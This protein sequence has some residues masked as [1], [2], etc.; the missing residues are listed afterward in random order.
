[1]GR[2][3]HMAWNKIGSGQLKDS[4]ILAQHVG[5]KE[6]DGTHIANKAITDAHIDLD[7][8]SKASF[9]LGTKK[10]VDY[11]QA[12]AGTI[13]AGESTVDLSSVIALGEAATDNDLG[14]VIKAPN[15]KVILTEGND[16]GKLLID[17]DTGSI[18]YGRITTGLEVRFFVLNNGNETAYTFPQDTAYNLQFPA[19]FTLETVSEMFAANEKFVDGAADVTTRL[20]VAQLAG[21]IFGAGYTL[22]KNGQPTLASG[23]TIAEVLAEAKALAE[24]N[25][26]DID[27]VEVTLHGTS[28]NATTGLVSKVTV[29][30]NKVAAIEAFDAGTRLDDT[31]QALAALDALVKSGDLVPK[32][33]RINKKADV[34]VTSYDLVSDLGVDPDKAPVATEL[35]VYVNGMLQMATEHYVEKVISGVVT[36][37]DFNPN[38][39]KVGDVVQ[40]RW[41]R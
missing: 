4:A 35:D 12:P 25:A 7:W 37:L 9:I 27:A 21:D 20:D 19:R 14:V 40:L 32:L 26:T 29:V 33:R 15:N 30:E 6:I 22:N 31:E 28:A 36:G 18:I 24:Q 38:V 17:E 41:M 34:E 39:V 10:V 5:Q 23:Q 2:V 13:S 8:A 1:M 11:V 16:A 3:L